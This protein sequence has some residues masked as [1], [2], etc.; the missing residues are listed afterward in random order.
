M[1]GPSSDRRVLVCDDSPSARAMIGMLLER[2]GFE[3]SLV[4][5]GEEAFRRCFEEPYDLVVTDV[6]MGTLG[7]VQ[8]CRLIRA[9]DELADLPVILMTASNDSRSRFW[10]TNAGAA[11]YLQ[12]DSMTSTLLPEVRRVLKNSRTRRDAPLR[13]GKP[14]DP[15]ECLSRLLDDLLFDAVVRNKVRSLMGQTEDRNQLA[16]AVLDLCADISR[17][18]YAVLRLDGDAGPTFHV[19]S[20]NPWPTRPSDTALDALGLRGVDSNQLIW[21]TALD[22][23]P[24]AAPIPPGLP[25]DYEIREGRHSLGQLSVYGGGRRLGAVDRESLAL[26]SEELGVPAQVL[27]LFEEK[28]RLA[29]TDTLTGLS[30]RRYIKS[31]LLHELAR[32]ERHGAPVSIAILDIDHFKQVNDGYGH[33]AGDRVL[34]NVSNL[35]TRCLRR[36]DIAG[37]WGG[38]EFLLVL[39]DT[40]LSGAAIAA[41]RVRAAIEREGAVHGGPERVTASIGVA[42]FCSGEDAESLVRRADEALYRAKELGRNRAVRA[43]SRDLSVFEKSA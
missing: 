17:F 2:E 12:K 41:E 38:E 26:V 28:N 3:V 22:P 25:D 8:L 9:S 40:S 30:N 42:E 24:D 27:F 33:Q 6:R 14:R 39:A 13:R 43:G 19:H 32:A 18:E 37:R 5:S 23:S 31:R 34:V 11:A 7:G 4:D 16:Q 36:I 35:I 29:R 1:E 20:R 15:L 21:H 10:G